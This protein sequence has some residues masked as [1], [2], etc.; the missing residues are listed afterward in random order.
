M[1]K[2]LELGLNFFLLMIIVSS[3][4]VAVNSNIDNGIS[5]TNGNFFQAESEQNNLDDLNFFDVTEFTNTSHQINVSRV[6]TANEYGYTTSY[7]RIRLYLSESASGTIDAFN[8]TI[9]SHELQDTKYLEIYSPNGTDDDTKILSDFTTVEENKSTTFVIKIPSVGKNQLISIIIRMDHLNAISFQE[10][11]KLEELSYPYL[12]NLSFLPLI[13]FPITHYEIQWKIGKD[14]NVNLENDSIHPTRDFY[15]GT[16]S[17][18]IS[19]LV[20]ENITELSTI[21]RF[22]LNNSENGSYNLTALKNRNFIPA[23]IPTLATNLTSYL[24]FNYFQ[25]ASTKIEFTELKS[26]VTVSE[27]G[28][29][30]TKHEITLSNIGMES[31]SILSTALGGPTFPEIRFYI[32]KNARK[33]GLRDNYGNLTPSVAL[34]SVINKKIVNIKPRIQI[35]KMAKYN[36]YLS[37]QE[38]VSDL[39]KDLGGGKVQLQIP[40]SM[41]FN[42]TVQRFEFNLLLPHGSSYNLTSIIGGIEQRTLRNSVINSS[43]RQKELLGIFDKTG[44]KLIFEDFTPL[45]NKY[46]SINFGLSFLYFLKTPFTI[47]ILFLALGI[48]YTIIR[49]LSFGFKPLQITLE[50]IPLDLIK[51]FVKDY[52]EKT[53]IREQ[54]LK[55]DRK[56]KSKNI[57]AREY[58]QTR[59][60]LRNRQQ[61]ID[62][63][64]VTVSRKLAEEDSRYRIS[65]RSIEV[66][67]ANREDIL[68]NIESLERKKMQGRIGKEA[69]AKLKINYNKQLRKANNEVDKV[70]IDLRSL[71]TK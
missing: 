52:E 60:I 35:E 46:I 32:P 66:A 51:E 36:L 3:L 44:F 4:F 7:T 50:E 10:N 19:G 16:P 47:C 71:L 13:S 25:Q 29:I 30:T 31:G 12:F 45:S 39:M 5:K 20:F 67:E 56:R 69:Y 64:I 58:E 21:N 57:K 11:A 59:I 33:I 65:M 28:Y 14:I 26:V 34:D 70:L 17:Q 53:A 15:T 8:Y 62:R 1:K 68:Q 43:I 6:I 22:L 40:L 55:L 9:P 24:S 2:K 48:A 63:S 41:N 37:Y 18:D 27:W 61:G 54:I 49:N 42:W 38:Q 23:Y